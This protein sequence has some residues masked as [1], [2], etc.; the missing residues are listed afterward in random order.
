L[1]SGS[2]GLSWTASTDDVGVTG[3]RILRNG[4]EIDTVA[5][6]VYTDAGVAADT[7]YCYRVL[8]YDESGNES[9]LSDES[10]SDT[11]WKV[12][13]ADASAFDVGSFSDIVAAPNGNLHIAYYHG[14]GKDLKYAVHMA[15]VWTTETVASTG[16]TG[17]YPSIAL[18][19]N[20]AA[21]I[22]YYEYGEPGWVVDEL[23]HATNASGVWTTE[24]IGSGGWFS[25]LAIDS[26]DHLHVGYR[27]NG[28]RHASNASG[29]WQTEPVAAPDFWISIAV[30]AATNVHLS[31]YQGYPA[32]DLLY[33]TN[34]TGTW[35]A[36]PVDSD[37]AGEFNSLALD[38]N[39]KAHLSYCEYFGGLRYASNASGD[40]VSELVDASGCGY[41]SLALDTDGHVHISYVS[42]D[43][44]MHAGNATGDWQLDTIDAA[45]PTGNYYAYATAITIDTDGAVH[46][47]Y[48]APG[49][50]LGY[51]TTR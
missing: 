23:K 24:I 15:G 48:Y 34:R 33:F 18:D 13:T 14:G 46:I 40:W 21:H 47:S 19:S 49:R 17:E 1:P 29:N 26:Q 38:A 35:V 50:K 9:S 22:S 4:I 41:T 2:I 45:E 27:S 37:L 8:A 44:L 43:H 10:C 6:P 30:D 39:N 11:R 20:G 16:M 3:Y 42:G 5:Q 36:E 25:A 31:A 7:R 28:L 51:A 32:N 12:S